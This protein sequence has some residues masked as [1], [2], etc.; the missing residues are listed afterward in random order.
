[1]G[2]VKN[3]QNAVGFSGAQGLVPGS[4][5]ESGFLDWAL[6]DGGLSPSYVGTLWRS[7]RHMEGAGVRFDRFTSGAAAVEEARPFLAAV[8]RRGKRHA[9][10][11]YQ[12]GLIHYAAYLGLED[13]KGIPLKWELAK[14]PRRRLDPYT[15]AEVAAI[16][17]ALRPGYKGLRQGAVAFLLAHTGLRKAEVHS[18]WDTDLNQDRGAVLLRHALKDGQPRWVNLPDTAWDPD[19]RL[20]RYLATRAGL[21]PGPLWLTEAGAPL[22]LA[23]FASDLFELRKRSG[24][25][26]N[27]NRWRHTRGT[28]GLVLNVPEDVQQAEWGHGDGKSTAHYR[29]GDQGQRREVLAACG[30]PGYLSRQQGVRLVAAIKEV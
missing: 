2:L 21:S 30:V 16:V 29:H 22:T 7:L 1:M 25:K 5:M 15:A 8:A 19:S 4:C 18:F 12:K 3:R 28:V 23:G 20:Q 10:V 14:V 13:E 9:L 26:L 27:F 11:N 24:V 17:A 6:T